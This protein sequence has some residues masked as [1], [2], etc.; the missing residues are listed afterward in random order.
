MTKVSRNT[1]DTFTSKTFFTDLRSV[2]GQEKTIE[3]DAHE[4]SFLPGKDLSKSRMPITN[5]FKDLIP[6]QTLLSSKNS[7]TGLSATIKCFT[8]YL[9]IFDQTEAL[10]KASELLDYAGEFFKGQEDFDSLML[11]TMPDKCVK[12][13]S[14]RV[15]T[16][17]E[18]FKNQIADKGHVLIPLSIKDGAP[19]FLYMTKDTVI[20]FNDTKDNLR[21]PDLIESKKDLLT[22]E[23]RLKTK[24]QKVLFLKGADTDL[25][26]Q[27]K[28]FTFIAEISVADTDTREM[29]LSLIYDGIPAFLDASWAPP[30][31]GSHYYRKER[32]ELSPYHLVRDL[33]H[34]LFIEL[35]PDKEKATSTYKEIRYAQERDI[36]C[37]YHKQQELDPN[38]PT[39][40]ISIDLDNLC[41]VASKLYKKG[42]LPKEELEKTYASAR[43]VKAKQKRELLE[44]K[45]EAKSISNL[46]S[47]GVRNIAPLQTT[48]QTQSFTSLGSK[49]LKRGGSKKLEIP[50]LT[51]FQDP[52]NC[53]SDLNAILKL[54]TSR[55]KDWEKVWP[56]ANHYQDDFLKEWVIKK[57]PAPN[58][59][60][61][62]AIPAKDR[63]Q[64][65][66]NLNEIAKSLDNRSTAMRDHLLRWTCYAIAESLVRNHPSVRDLPGDPF[67]K[68]PPTRREFIFFALS[69]L[70]YSFDPDITKRFKDLVAY[71]VPNLPLH[72]PYPEP[73]NSSFFDGVGL[74]AAQFT[75]ALGDRYTLTQFQIFNP[76]SIKDSLVLSHQLREEIY[77]DETQQFLKKLHEEYPDPEDAIVPENE[78]AFEAAKRK[79]K[80][81]NKHLTTVPKNY[82]D[83]EALEKLLNIS[84]TMYP[85]KNLS[86][87]WSGNGSYLKGPFL[88]EFSELWLTDSYNRSRYP[89]NGST[90]KMVDAM[91]RSRYPG[92]TPA[93]QYM[94]F[95]LKDAYLNI[96][97]DPKD[98]INRWIGYTLENLQEFTIAP[99]S[100]NRWDFNEPQKN[101]ARRFDFMWRI[102]FHPGALEELLD[103][104]PQYIDKLSEFSERL[105]NEG[106]S[107]ENIS[108]SLKAILLIL[109]MKRTLETARPDLVSSLP[110]C[111]ELL[112]KLVIPSGD[113][114]HHADVQFL[115]LM[116]IFVEDPDRYRNARPDEDLC[117]IYLAASSSDCRDDL[118]AFYS[119]PDTIRPF[120]SWKALKETESVALEAYLTTKMKE[121]ENFRNR[122]LNKACSFL[123]AES[124]SEKSWKSNFSF[125]SATEYTSEIG[126]YEIDSNEIS[127]YASGSRSQREL[128]RLIK[129]GM[130]AKDLGVDTINLL[131]K[132]PD[133]DLFIIEASGKQYQVTLDPKGSTYKIEQKINGEIYSFVWNK[134]NL[135]AYS[136]LQQFHSRD[137]QENKRIWIAASSDAKF[138]FENKEGLSKEI[139]LKKIEP[140]D[141]LWSAFTQLIGY[142]IGS[143]LVADN[144][145][146]QFFLKKGKTK[147]YFEV[148]DN[149]AHSLDY[150]G[151]VLVPKQYDAIPG[152]VLE[153]EGTT[154]ILT[155]VPEEDLLSEQTISADGKL[156]Q[157]ESLVDRLVYATLLPPEAIEEVHAIIDGISLS[158]RLSPLEM[159]ILTLLGEKNSKNTQTLLPSNKTHFI[160]LK[161]A[162]LVLE[163][164]L[165]FPPEG[166]EEQFAQAILPS[167]MIVATMYPSYLNAEG[168]LGAIKLSKQQ[169][170]NLLT[171]LVHVLP[172]AA[173]VSDNV[174][175]WIPRALST[176]S[177]IRTVQ[178]LSSETTK[179]LGTVLNTPHVKARL[180]ALEKDLL[181]E[182]VSKRHPLSIPKIST[183]IDPN[184]LI[185]AFKIYT[186]ERKETIKT[187]LFEAKEF[188]LPAMMDGPL[189]IQENFAAYYAIAQEITP[190]ELKQ[191]R[192]LY[193]TSNLTKGNRYKFTNAFSDVLKNP[194]GF[195]SF[196]CLQENLQKHQEVQAKID[197]NLNNDAYSPLE[198]AKDRRTKE[199][200]RS[201]FTDFSLY[202]MIRTASSL[203]FYAVSTLFALVKDNISIYFG[204]TVVPLSTQGSNTPRTLMSFDEAS[205]KASE[206]EFLSYLTG[207]ETKYVQT[208]EISLAQ[209]PTYNDVK[210]QAQIDEYNATREPLTYSEKTTLETLHSAL[211]VKINLTEDRLQA[212]EETLILKAAPKLRE[213]SFEDLLRDITSKDVDLQALQWLF[214]NGSEEEFAKRTTLTNEERKEIFQEMSTFLVEKT[215]INQLRI[216]KD[217]LA[218]YLKTKNAAEK[219]VLFDQ[220]VRSL[221]HRRGYDL[222][223]ECRAKLLYEAYQG[224]CLRSVQIEKVASIFKTLSSSGNQTLFEMPTGAG[225][226]HAILPQSN[227][228]TSDGTR[229][230]F[231][232]FP[233]PIAAS[234]IASN[235]EE[236]GK[237][238]IGID[239]MDFHRSTFMSSETLGYLYR[240]LELDVAQRR[241]I[242]ISSE[243]VRALQLHLI[244]LMIE[245]KEK[246]L[247]LEQKE[248]ASLLLKILQFIRTKGV[249]NIDEARDTLSPFDRIIYTHGGKKH[250][251]Q[252]ELNT[253]DE[254]F[255]AFLGIK[256]VKDKILKDE[257]V[258]IS[259]QDYK[260]AIAPAVAGHMSLVFDISNADYDS[261]IGYVLGDI[262]DMPEFINNH[263]KKEEI[264]LVRGFLMMIIPEALQGHVNVDYGFSLLHR[265]NKGFAI[266][267][268]SA[269]T[270]KETE[271]APSEYQNHHEAAGKTLIA[272]FQTGLEESHFEECLDQIKNLYTV[273]KATGRLDEDSDAL[274]AFGRVF[275]PGEDFETIKKTYQ[276]INVNFIPSRL[277]HIKHNPGAVCYY[278]KRFIASQISIYKTTLESTSFDFLKQFA[279]STSM[280]ATPQETQSHGKDTKFVKMLGA[281]G[282]I[283][284]HFFEKGEK[285]FSLE[286]DSYKKLLH[287]VANNLKT[288][289]NAII[290]VGGLFKGHSSRKVAEDLFDLIKNDRPDIQEF[291]Y[292]D[293]EAKEFLAIS[294]E[295][296]STIPLESSKRDP[297]SRCI[298]FD[299]PR[300]VGSDTKMGPL[301]SGLVLVDGN[302]TRSNLGQAI[303]RMRQLPFGQRLS[304]AMPSHMHE[305]LFKNPEMSIKEKKE[306]LYAHLM[307]EEKHLE[308]QA[309]LL[310]I[311][312]QIN[313]EIRDIVLSAILKAS[314][315]SAARA[316]FMRD[317]HELVT[318]NQTSPS[319][320]YGDIE[321]DVPVEED[322]ERFLKKAQD[323]VQK[324]S[325]LTRS[326]KAQ[327]ISKLEEYKELWEGANKLTLPE[328]TLSSSVPKTGECDVL[329]QVEQQMQMQ[330]QQEVKLQNPNLLIRP[331]SPWSDTIDLFTPGWESVHEIDTI[332]YGAFRWYKAMKKNWDLGWARLRRDNEGLATV[333]NIWL[334]QIGIIYA[335]IAWF[336][337]EKIRILSTALFGGLLAY[338]G[339]HVFRQRVQVAPPLF[340]AKDLARQELGNTADTLFDKTNLFVT[341]NYVNLEPNSVL[342]EPELLFSP[343]QKTNYKLLF[344]LDEGKTQAVLVDQNDTRFLHEIFT[345]QQALNVTQTRK[346]VLYDLETDSL[347]QGMNSR[348]TVDELKEI[349]NFHSYTM[350]AKLLGRRFQFKDA[351]FELHKKK[352]DQIT[353]P[354][355]QAVFDRVL[356]SVPKITKDRLP[357]SKIGQY[358]AKA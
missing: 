18:Q 143:H 332:A 217:N 334:W 7:F 252:F 71:M 269:N 180:M 76:N 24:I 235:E 59:P 130:L 181:S 135:S 321:K 347:I 113:F 105:F 312:Q 91:D 2:P 306:V 315:F 15:Q 73:A 81:L 11:K 160:G 16:L 174:K 355:M 27:D 192:R 345:K 20:V 350:Q 38:A 84:K 115:S 183:Y 189:S 78:T 97:I 72:S 87:S 49:D 202:S 182:G 106:I 199:W 74:A 112:K 231:N 152:L 95:V 92:K 293:E 275:L 336:V 70:H 127:I 171:C 28:L 146:S 295:S 318:E 221:Q 271:K 17:A 10:T 141:P 285:I 19:L 32:T 246:V 323:R 142:A 8:D 166:T 288:D 53:S 339:F 132:D 328:T 349:P 195:R 126:K 273:E 239:S 280:T 255:T 188:L 260:E 244:S 211:T 83:K 155:P 198:L 154:K 125:L 233:K 149:K 352:A 40:P 75:S 68:I 111:L 319:Y 118:E 147:L 229:L 33:F 133:S 158:K 98:R 279:S 186:Q 90:T 270:P 298:F 31:E 317:Y 344:L 13:R 48:P 308:G 173:P 205:L 44:N 264:C 337:S 61:W 228:E 314:S 245:E 303:G 213:K 41:R 261:F 9:E 108:L 232:V 297:S 167:A 224:I 45:H 191:L 272:L 220:F 342:F 139:S 163:A 128:N 150:P 85:K 172:K 177:P 320:L 34:S 331:V 60:Y 185:D 358:L 169:E 311:K 148:K 119:E 283:P 250:L 52:K 4:R 114:P 176:L 234:N 77:S 96:F 178:G 209:G 129:D 258:T 208:E 5:S 266:P 79:R 121:D 247:T 203:C 296:G 140:S 307:S 196:A 43:Y 67:K 117:A 101:Q 39:L 122:V 214:L 301:A 25:F 329:L 316:I 299:M 94:N 292:F 157:P 51:Q 137:L 287:S 310:A 93:V 240:K 210:E 291:A 357:V 259:S 265:K 238:G 23:P 168:S 197:A 263:L 330:P 21:H 222:T 225:K 201:Y 103:T 204:H 179:L 309:N 42:L 109:G 69:G 184:D 254:I 56:A 29:Q 290:D 268:L 193:K 26:A 341:N 216:I 236:M 136:L 294:R 99:K 190:D 47:F 243:S 156:I 89:D 257:Q 110:N 289:H 251:E 107:N 134:E 55:T 313:A 159:K 237:V 200:H 282:F 218:R 54:A 338:R 343:E 241:P 351:E 219:P 276:K 353:A 104:Q 151:Y 262:T 124:A 46:P 284:Y 170:I 305:D 281:K 131:S 242:N 153:K 322:L 300:T 120:A 253:I 278:F 248:C 227:L 212:K 274:K 286:V 277:P 230:T 36:L 37:V 348:L 12:P 22:E 194:K 326:E 63:L 66:D 58:D 62:E 324:L 223:P 144:K 100:T 267:Y 356:Q 335:G 80:I 256:T 346:V 249:A 187:M 57:I 1:T 161:I 175:S 162:A 206:R 14:E 86:R 102:F 333:L 82:P 6:L 88:P 64:V 123:G 304:Y 50:K 207:L 215:Q 340:R 116:A 35:S 3:A 138:L 165:K 354:K 325:C 226:T 30:E 145:L 164:H 302:T 327:E 65:L